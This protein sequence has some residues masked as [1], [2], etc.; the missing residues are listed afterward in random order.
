MSF[1]TYSEFRVNQISEADVTLL[2]KWPVLPEI[3]ENFKVSPWWSKTGS[4]IP[5]LTALFYG[6]NRQDR[7]TH[8]KLQVRIEDRPAAQRQKTGFKALDKNVVEPFVISE[9]SVQIIAK[10]LLSQIAI[11]RRNKVHRQQKVNCR[12]SEAP[13]KSVKEEVLKIPV[14]KLWSSRELPIGRIFSNRLRTGNSNKWVYSI[15]QDGL[16]HSYRRDGK[17]EIF[18][19]SLMTPSA[20]AGNSNPSISGQF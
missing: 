6:E 9:R 15:T 20:A 5:E 17:R 11:Q 12:T 16:S 8:L 14:R 10:K 7:E 13:V 19:G 1:I 4:L 3:I 2:P 18:V